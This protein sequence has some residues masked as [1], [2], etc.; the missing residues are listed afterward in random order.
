MGQLRQHT[1]PKNIGDFDFLCGP[2]H[3][4]TTRVPDCSI[5]TIRDERQ[6]HL[7]R[8]FYRL[9]QKRQCPVSVASHSLPH[10]RTFLLHSR[11]L[12]FAVI[13]VAQLSVSLRT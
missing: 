13:V 1:A 6:E 10:A 8:L 11:R 7:R 12:R 9:G 3:L 2:E 5:G 4:R